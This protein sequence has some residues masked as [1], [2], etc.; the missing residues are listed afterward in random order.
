M[1]YQKLV[2]T[3]K[4]KT[5][6]LKILNPWILGSLLLALSACEPDSPP[7][8]PTIG[9]THKT[10][11]LCEGNFMW[12]NAQLD[13]I[14]MDS[15]SFQSNVFERINNKPLGDVLQSALIWDD[16]VYLVVNNSGKVIK[17]N[18]KTLKLI[19]SQAGLGSPR[20]LLPVGN[21]L[22]LTDLYSSKISILDS[23]TLQKL[24]EIP[25]S[26]WTET[27]VQWN[28]LV[29]VASYRKGV[30]LFN[31]DGTA[32]AQPILR[33]DSTSK[34]LTVDSYNRLWVASTGGAGFSSLKRFDS[35]YSVNPT[36]SIVPPAAISQVISNKKGD[37]LYLAVGNTIWSLPVSATRM[38]DAILLA[39][40]FKQLYG[41][42]L[43]K[44]GKYLLIADANDYVSNGKVFV[45][46]LQSKTTLKTFETGVNPNGFLSY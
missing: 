1:E 33:G 21:R 19:N 14:D 20:Y 27:M 18:S 46:D 38:E 5:T 2:L 16:F 13:I 3:S 36:V 26:G 41:L 8:Q 11:I 23:G 32:A 25:A 34:F 10:L 44:D 9:V 12:G 31:T 28:S 7:I 30:Y 4:T 39:D 22:W 45:F 43:S 17:L 40:G 35:P 6:W 29:A 37:T 15:L 42:N 24:A